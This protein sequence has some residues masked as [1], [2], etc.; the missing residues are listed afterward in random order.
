MPC[1]EALCRGRRETFEND[2]PN[3]LGQNVETTTPVREEGPMNKVVLTNLGGTGEDENP[4]TTTT[5]MP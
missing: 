4:P 5:S 2:T 1:F 3:K